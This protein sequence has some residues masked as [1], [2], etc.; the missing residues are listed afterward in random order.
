MPRASWNGAVI[1]DSDVF[2]TVEGNVYF[3]P[4]RVRREHLRDS[5]T[6]SVCSWKGTA[7]YYDVVV[8]DEVNHD[9]AWYYP[10]PKPAARN[11]KDHV[12]FWR[13]VEVER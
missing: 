2:E 11:I 5:A 3:P 7:H 13:G 1:A 10:D 4:E 8:G 12:A 6:T 9:A